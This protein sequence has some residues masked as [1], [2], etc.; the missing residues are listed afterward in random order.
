MESNAP[1]QGG[2]PLLDLESVVNTYWET[3][4]QWR[5]AGF[6][7]T[8]DSL[9]LASPQA[10]TQINYDLIDPISVKT[11]VV[12]DSCLTPLEEGE[13]DPWDA[14][15]PALAEWKDEAQKLEGW[16]KLFRLPRF[17]GL[18]RP[19]Y[20]D[21][22]PRLQNHEG[23]PDFR[24]SYPYD[25]RQMY[26]FWER[27]HRTA[28]QQIAR[29]REMLKTAKHLVEMTPTELVEEVRDVLTKFEGDVTIWR[30]EI[31]FDVPNVDLDGVD[32]GTFEVRLFR[33]NNRWDVTVSGGNYDNAH[34][35]TTEEGF[36]CL[37]EGEELFHN[38]MDDGRLF[39]AM[40]I[41]STLVRSYNPSSCYSTVSKIVDGDGT[42]C[43]DCGSHVSDDYAY[44]CC[45]CNETLCEGCTKSCDSCQSV[46]CCECTHRCSCSCGRAEWRCDNCR[47][48]CQEC[49]TFIC[50]I[51]DADCDGTHPDCIPPEEE[52]EEDETPEPE[53]T[54]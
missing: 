35:H 14:V 10:V 7:A 44:T 12:I 11:A 27:E 38:T 6:P 19:E 18:S 43:I 23:N 54:P 41:V 25:L 40:E 36:L 8:R 1:P 37:G 24:D 42:P 49:G 22:T 29:L 13:V 5:P 53:E 33:D 39:D 4:R 47:P 52:D 30:G 32:F 50:G 48:D 31:T 16:R 26:E 20:D 9:G 3:T 34:P 28:T 46:F 21:V 51:C 45:A 17:D 15:P 2:P